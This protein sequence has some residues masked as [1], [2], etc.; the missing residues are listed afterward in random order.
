MKTTEL[1]VEYIII[2]METII[3]IILLFLSIIGNDMLNFLMYCIDKIFPTIVLMGVCYVLGLLTDRLADIIY[4]RRRKRIKKE[5]P[6]EA[7]SS[8]IV[9]KNY[10]RVNYAEF[11][12]SRIRILR[13][14]A[15][16][17]VLIA[18]IGAFY[19]SMYQ[20]NYPTLDKWIFAIFIIFAGIAHYSHK[21]LMINY[22]KKTK[23][24]SE[25]KLKGVRCHEHNMN[26]INYIVR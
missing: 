14:T 7:E 26:K 12:L 11:T 13:S 16:N 21:Q 8:L 20:N 4:E 25:A 9:W 15:I 5:N 17:L 23:A 24:I 3:W 1:Y 18:F 19:A 2:G 22:Y 10:D 6:I